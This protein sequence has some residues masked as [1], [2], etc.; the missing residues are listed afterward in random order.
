MKQENRNPLY[1]IVQA[2]ESAKK[3]K[4]HLDMA[5]ITPLLNEHM[6]LRKFSKGSYIL[7]ADMPCEKIYYIF[8]GAF[9]II[10]Y[11]SEGKS[12]IPFYEK[13]PYFLGVNAAVL[14]CP[15][16]KTNIIAKETCYILEISPSYFVQ[17]IQ[18]N[19]EFCFKILEM[20]CKRAIR[21]INYS[22]EVTLY[23]NPTR[24]MI[25]IINYCNQKTFS[26]ESHTISARNTQIADDL[27]I[28][29]RTL[30]RSINKLKEKNLLSTVN[31]NI[32]VTNEQLIR[33]QDLL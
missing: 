23:D 15:G 26:H 21:V 28:S 20:T 6:K 3:A 4:E 22:D 30:Y 27:G 17:S 29:A 12:S 18:A 13:A 24:L 10:Q 1:S 7:T 19:V 31:G 9:V 5:V 11:N 2:V 8:E 33:M 16:I 32:T 25:Y 14:S